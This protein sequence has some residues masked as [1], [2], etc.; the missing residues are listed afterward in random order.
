MHVEEIKGF[1]VLSHY[2]GPV[3]RTK[4]E[5]YVVVASDRISQC[6]KDSPSPRRRHWWTQRHE[7]VT[8]VCDR[9]ASLLIAKD[10]RLSGA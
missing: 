10:E 5:A 3:Y 4:H 1:V 9:F 6:I 8:K 2:R 7:Y